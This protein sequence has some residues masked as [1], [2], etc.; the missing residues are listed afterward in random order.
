VFV[1]RRG[2]R[3]VHNLLRLL[4]V[5]LRHNDRCLKL[6]TVEQTYYIFTIIT[7]LNTSR[8]FPYSG[9]QRPTAIS[10][11]IHRECRI[12]TYESPKCRH[13]RVL[14]TSDSTASTTTAGTAVK[15]YSKRAYLQ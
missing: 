7:D 12:H 3:L 6:I 1:V 10:K 15:L 11:T 5:I 4:D 13:S 9:W 2:E 14:R 8:A